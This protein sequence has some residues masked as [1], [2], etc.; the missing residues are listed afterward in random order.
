MKEYMLLIRGG[1]ARMA[2]LTEEQT[3][4]HMAKWGSYM[5]ELGQKGHLVGGLPFTQEGRILTNHGTKSDVVRSEAG[6]PIGGYLQIKA[7]DYDHALGLA[8]NCPVFEHD[9]SI[10][11]REIMPMDM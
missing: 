7:D 6:E 2:E 1:D 4:E 9:G 10:E 8:K 5:G 3:Q 11:I